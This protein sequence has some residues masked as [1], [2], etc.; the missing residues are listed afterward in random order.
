M[1]IVLSTFF[2]IGSYFFFCQATVEVNSEIFIDGFREEEEINWEGI[3]LGEITAQVFD[4]NRTIQ[5]TFESTGEV[6]EAHRAHGT[7][8]IFNS[9]Y[10]IFKE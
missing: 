5:E 1:I 7:I 3:P 4:L 9:F 10:S 8:R 2:L 6:T